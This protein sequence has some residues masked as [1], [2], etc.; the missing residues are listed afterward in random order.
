MRHLFIIVFCFFYTTTFAQKNTLRKQHVIFKTGVGYEFALNNIRANYITDQ[1]TDLNDKGLALQF[2]SAN[3][4]IKK[5]W[6]VE[7]FISGI[8]TKQGKKRNQLFNTYM[9]DKWGGQ[10]YYNPEEFYYDAAASGISR[11][12]GGIGITYKIE[13]NRF[14]YIPKFFIGDV[15]V[16]LQ[17]ANAYLKERNNNTILT[18]RY[19]AG[20]TNKDR[21]FGGPAASV[22]YRFNNRLGI[23]FDA[24][25]FVHHTKITYT[26]TLTNL[27]NNNTTTI[28]YNYN[29]MM[30]RLNAGLSFSLTL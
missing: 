8:A 5:N 19:Y 21:I 30:H 26:E 23:S 17:S 3:I 6:G 29:K 7:L 18:S 15:G 4:Y 20:R 2:F 22:M 16:D 14:T 12:N 1:L 11:F 10:Y 27:A 28:P 9:T 25:W 13:K 24:S